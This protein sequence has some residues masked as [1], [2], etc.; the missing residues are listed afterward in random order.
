[1]FL[2]KRLAD[3]PYWAE[4]TILILAIMVLVAW[5]V[6]KVYNVL[7]PIDWEKAVAVAHEMDKPRP[8]AYQVLPGDSLWGIATKYYPDFHT[9]EIVQE[10]RKLNGMTQNATIYPYEVLQLP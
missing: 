8:K 6:P 2:I 4:M 3:L 5:T 1:M 10:I 9:G 7:R